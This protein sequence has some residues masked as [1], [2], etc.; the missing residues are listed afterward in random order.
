MAMHE[1]GC[2]GGE[3]REGGAGGADGEGEGEGGGGGDWAGGDEAMNEACPGSG[4]MRT[5]EKRT[6][7]VHASWRSLGQTPELRDTA[8]EKARRAP[9]RQGLQRGFRVRSLQRRALRVISLCR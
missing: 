6:V 5:S 7:S 8:R 9:Q 2:A 4:L 3:G 1:L